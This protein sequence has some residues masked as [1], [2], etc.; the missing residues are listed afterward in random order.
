MKGFYTPSKWLCLIS[1][2]LLILPGLRSQSARIELVDEL[3]PLCSGDLFF[4]RIFEPS[5]S[6]WEWS[7][8]PEWAVPLIEDSGP[9]G[10]QIIS[11][12]YNPTPSP[13]LITGSFI[14][15]I[16]GTQEILT[17]KINF[18]V[19]PKLSCL[20][21]LDIPFDQSNEDVFK[22]KLQHPT[23]LVKAISI[24]ER[25]APG[26][27]PD[28]NIY[29]NPAS[30]HVIIEWPPSEIPLKL[31]LCHSNASVVNEVNLQGHPNSRCELNMVGLSDGV[32]LI[33]LIFHEGIRTARLVK[34]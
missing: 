24:K 27:D 31:L 10:F 28:V 18:W 21:D 29:P 7:F 9:N 13:V 30:D 11:Q 34:G 32:Y 16:A 3:P 5:V 23:D 14:G 15:Y 20:F 8:T 26:S 1:L 33:V 4:Y 22:T 12:L 17:R 2:C 25:S 19:R 6:Y